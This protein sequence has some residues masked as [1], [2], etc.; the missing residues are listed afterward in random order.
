MPRQ[1]L[2]L[3]ADYQPLNVTTFR[4]GYKLLYKGKAEV[5]KDDVTQMIVSQS[6][7][8]RPRIIRL[9]KYLYLPYRQLQLTRTHIFKRDHHT[10]V[11]CGSTSSLTL[12]HII[13]RSRGGQNTWENM[14]T[15]CFRCNNRKADQ[16]PEEAGL[17][18]RS[19]PFAPSFHYL[20]SLDNDL[21]FDEIS[22]GIGRQALV[23]ELV[24]S[25]HLECDAERRAGS[26]PVKGTMG[27][28]Q[29]TAGAGSNESYAKM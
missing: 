16:T 26:S 24:D 3:N 21:A 12:D 15:S 28:L 7:V 19:K 9:L 17:K 8:P 13:P 5:I 29:V 25:S 2:V 22:L 6:L 1:I 23:E 4:K 14:V 27:T 18:L 10:C 20:V 11:Y